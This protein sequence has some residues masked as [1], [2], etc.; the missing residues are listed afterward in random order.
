[1]LLLP[2]FFV[3]PN[4]T[5]FTELYGV[6]QVGLELNEF[7]IPRLFTNFFVFCLTHIKPLKK[8]SVYR[9]NQPVTT[10]R[11]RLTVRVTI[12]AVS[13]FIVFIAPP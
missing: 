6:T 13:A 3:N 2:C 9:I 5:L 10:I 8:I 7:M 1:M 4:S 11:I 12:I